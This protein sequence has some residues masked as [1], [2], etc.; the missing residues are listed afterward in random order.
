MKKI[1]IILSLALISLLVAAEFYVRSDRFSL[2]IRPF[3]VGPLQDVLGKD[4]EIGRIRVNFIPLSIEA[5]D[6]SLPDGR[7][8]RLA[9]VRKIRVYV[10]PLPLLFNKIRLPSIVVLEPRI[11]AERPKD[12]ELNLLPLTK[13]LR[14]NVA[15]MKPVPS[16]YRLMLKTIT[17]SQGAI[18]FKDSV[19]GVQ[20]SLTGLHA[21]TRVNLAG[22]SFSTHLK[23]SSVHVLAPS[24]AF[25][26][27]LT[28]SIRYDHR[29][30]TI[31]AF[32]LATADTVISVSGSIGSQADPALNMH[33]TARSG[34]QTIGKFT[35]LIK[36][37]KKERR[38]LVRAS[39][40]LRGTFTD[41][42][43]EGMFALSGISYNGFLFQD[44]SLSFSYRSKRLTMQGE[45]W[46]LVKAGKS[47]IVESIEAALGY[48]DR[49]VSIEHFHVGAGDFSLSLSGRADPQGGFDSH[50][51][52]ESRD[53]GETLSFLTAVPLEGG[54]SM[55]GSLTGVLN[56]P[57]FDG[58]FV[59][60]PLRVRGILF[61][62]AEGRIQFHDKKMSLMSVD[63]R[64]QSSRYFFTGSVD[65]GGM[66]PI[67]AARLKVLRSDVG[68]IVALFYR[69]LPLHFSATGDLAFDGT[70]REF[71]G[72]GRLSLDSGTAYGESF[73]KGTVTA[74]LTKERISFS[75]V[76][77]QKGSG[78]VQG[79]GWIGFDKTY[80]ASLESHGV[81]LKEVGLMTGVPVDG[82][83]ELKIESSGSFS[84]P[85]VTSVLEVDDL[86]VNESGVGTLSADVHISDKVLT[87]SA[88]LAGRRAAVKA[89]LGL[90]EPYAWI[91]EAA[92]N[93]DEFDPF[94][95]IGRKDLLGRVRTGIEGT[96][97]ARGNGT[98]RAERTGTVLIRHMGV[99]VG[100]YRMDNDGPVT[101]SLSNDKLSINSLRLSGQGTRIAV[102][103]SASL[104]KDIDVSLLGTASLSLL[105]PLFRD[106]E[107]SN[108]TAEVR[109]SIRDTW[110]NPDMAGE[111]LIRNGEIKIRDIAQKFSSLTG[112]LTFDRS[113]IVVDSVTGEMGGGTLSASGNAQLAGLTLGDFSSRVNFENVTVRYP[114]GLIS[115][116]SGDL[117]YDGN[118]FEQSLNGEVSIKK[119]RY[120]KRL[121]WKSMLVDIGRGLY[122]KKKTEAGWIGDTEINI[123]FYGKENIL[124][125][126]NLAKI[127]LDVDVFLRG[128]VNRPQLL[129]RI[130]ARKG[131]VYFRQNEFKILHGAVDFVDPNRMNPVLDIQAEIRVREYL[132]RL[133]VSGT[134]DRAVV[135][136]LS[137]PSL[138]DSD[139]LALLALGKTGTELKGREAGVGM[140]EAYSFATGQIQDIVESRARSL[141]GLD[142][143]QVDPYVSKGDTSVPRVTV[144][145]EIVQDKLYVTYSSNVGSTTPEQIFRIEYILNKHF[146]LVGERNELGNT[147]ADI[148]YR[149]EF[150]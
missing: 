57:H 64:Q 5:R 72:S 17:I 42:S 28:A 2:M 93:V 45:K 84:R 137:D 41:P 107:Y 102:T 14:S 106:L 36:Q 98:Q 40:S 23:N 108:G 1:L 65:L 133:A 95:V 82:S 32:E 71:T 70:V 74:A 31:D 112:K 142:R 87:G 73:T 88:R 144:G 37:L 68:S 4:A 48:N 58:S 26:G 145:K 116:L 128:T 54:I 117:Y 121:E 113:R 94:L 132:V 20:A 103:G 80:S 90:S 19:T 134:A 6:I 129:G 81:R 148:K 79:S 27:S 7:G 76:L 123:R 59:A 56:R 124:F 109:L 122:Q 100:D 11:F 118:A 30:F 53:K 22:D 91:M 149:F 33:L 85:L 24:P 115:T 63:I 12:G 38:S 135:T 138:P 147:G 21:V 125:Q 3:V 75:E 39:A 47:V 83:C 55:K 44:A 101:L 35:S 49:A 43:A 139:I 13:R 120:D 131:S 60:G 77:V 104:E 96:L 89:R 114:E 29:R 66:E 140:S 141:T 16:K 15:G 51:T 105:R 18:S 119:A 78:I 146:S 52:A 46:K 136:L 143:F 67:F 97:S 50:V 127:P 62:N 99:T 8:G 69:P 61:D 126:N 130:E 150:K 110:K 34:P 9:T 86:L 92:I 111:V 10:N 25:T